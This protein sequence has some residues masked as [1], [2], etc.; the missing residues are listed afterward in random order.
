MHAASVFKHLIGNKMMAADS[1]QELGTLLRHMDQCVSPPVMPQELLD[2]CDTEG[3]E[4]NGGGEFLIRM[5]N[6]VSNIESMLVR[7]VF[8]DRGDKEPQGSSKAIGAGDIGSPAVG[9][10]NLASVGGPP[11]GLFPGLG[12][13]H[14]AGFH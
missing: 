13:H 8:A 14:A 6:N 2:I 12:G 5:P 11:S 10:S 9:T 1:W 7:Y 4:H 3:N